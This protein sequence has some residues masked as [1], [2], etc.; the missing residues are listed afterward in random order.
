MPAT[1][2]DR[3]TLV[4]AVGI[5]IFACLAVA[6]L[7]FFATGGAQDTP[8]QTK[9]LFLGLEPE[10]RDK[11]LGTSE[12]EGSPLYFANPFGDN[13]FWLDVE[14]DDIVALNL[15]RPGSNDC[16]VKWRETMGSYIAECD[17]ERLT[18]RDLDRFEVTVGK[19]AA[20][21]PEDGVYVDLRV[22]EPAPGSADSTG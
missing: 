18:S 12:D 4:F 16:Q 13:G 11:I 8:T 14:N 15:I 20:D 2:D 21:S 17:G 22:V 10:L 5:I 1:A 19:Q 7:L 9:P 3:R 6:G